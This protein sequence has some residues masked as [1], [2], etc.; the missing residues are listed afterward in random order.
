MWGGRLK[1]Q[2][3]NPWRFNICKGWSDRKNIT[4]LLE[5]K[6]IAI[7]IFPQGNILQLFGG[8]AYDIFAPT[9]LPLHFFYFVGFNILNGYALE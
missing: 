7:F 5:I 3:P 8:D 2:P 1:P 6:K 4:Y 9:P